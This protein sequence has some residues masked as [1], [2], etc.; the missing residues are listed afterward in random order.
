VA[1]SDPGGLRIDKARQNDTIPLRPNI[2]ARVVLE[3]RSV[4]SDDATSD[5]QRV[6][7]PDGHPPVGAFL[8]VPLRIQ[9]RPIGMIGVANRPEPYDDEH[10]QH[11][12]A[13]P[14]PPAYWPTSGQTKTLSH[15]K[16]AEG[17]RLTAW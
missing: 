3:N 15:I 16:A 17:F 9:D 7:Q 8:G 12:P 2:F 10:E 11:S 5:P 6:G 4:R 13:E 14:E 1:K